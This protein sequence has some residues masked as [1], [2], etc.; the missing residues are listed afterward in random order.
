MSRADIICKIQN[1][2]GRFMQYYALNRLDLAVDLFSKGE[3]TRIWMPDKD[4][5]AVGSEAVGKTLLQLSAERVAKGFNRD[6]HLTHC[7]VFK[8][9]DESGEA[10][11]TF[12]TYSFDVVEDGK[13]KYGLEFYTTRFD[14]RFVPEDGEWKYSSMHWYEIVS[15][16]PWRLSPEDDKGAKLKKL[17]S[18]P[19]PPAPGQ[20]TS[21]EDFQAIQR[22]QAKFSHDNRKNAVEKLFANSDEITLKMPNLFR[23]TKRGRDAVKR[24]LDKLEQL[25]VEN[26]GMYICV[27][28]VTSP[29]IE[30]S[31][32]GKTAEGTWLT[33]TYD[34]KGPAFG[35]EKPPYRIVRN[36]GYIHNRFIKED[37]KWKILNYELELLLTQTPFEYDPVNVHTR[38]HRMTLKDNN[39]RY[40]TAELG[41]VYPDDACEVE[42]M[43]PYWLNH[44]RRGNMGPYIREHMYNE[45][46]EI[47]FQSRFT[48]REAPPVVGLESMLKKFLGTPFQY[49]HQQVCYHTDTTPIV[50]VSADGNYAT[51]LFFDQSW[52]PYDASGNTDTSANLVFDSE[53]NA[54]STGGKRI[55]SISLLSKYLHKFVKVNGEWKHYMLDWEPIICFP[56]WELAGENSRGWSGADTDEMYPKLWEEYQFTK[57]RK[58]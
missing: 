41:G 32:D 15:F 18:L 2:H 31:E 17:A 22:V 8:V 24:Q 51:A 42:S 40:S 48:G 34:V 46:E 27:P 30:V 54:K 39:W 52:T 4:I 44:L 10:L 21:P 35:Y 7:P 58:V 14:C 25:E 19:L 20:Y 53:W 55:N 49:H 16:V 29:V 9:T 33:M 36:L 11:A 6:I 57:K 50:E 12:D 47:V 5:D 13:G 38:Y 3:N 28:L 56:D 23:G 1:T 37:G 45:R 43:L 26:Q